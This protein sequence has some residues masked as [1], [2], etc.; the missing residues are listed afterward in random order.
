MNLNNTGN[1]TVSDGDY[2]VAD[3]LSSIHCVEGGIVVLLGCA[4][5]YRVTG[6]EV[7]CYGPNTSVKEHLG[8]TVTRY[9]HRDGVWFV[10]DSKTMPKASV[11]GEVPVRQTVMV[12][13]QATPGTAPTGASV[14]ANAAKSEA[15]PTKEQDHEAAAKIL[16]GCKRTET[17]I[18]K[19]A[20]RDAVDLLTPCFDTFVVLAR[21]EGGC[22]VLAVHGEPDKAI[23]MM[24]SVVKLQGTNKR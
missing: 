7:R 24:T 12:P 10:V 11:P 4:Y 18:A 17:E 15:P 9:E 16:E 3:D 22:L 23:D 6:G 20:A 2:V 13:A 8:G 5:A 14:S 1:V 21:K 19:Q